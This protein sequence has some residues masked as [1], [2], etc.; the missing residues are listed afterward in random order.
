MK[1]DYLIVGAGLYGAVFAHEATERGKKCLVIEKRSHVGGNVFT[2]DIE[3]IQVHKYGAHIFHTNNK[4]IW[5]FVNKFGEFNGFINSPI[6]KYKNRMYSLPFNMNTFYQMWGIIDPEEAWNKIKLQKLQ[7]NIKIPKNLEEQAISLVGYDIYK[8]LIKGYTE[9]QW[10]R[11][12]RDLPIDIIKRL[13]VRYT[14][15]NNYFSDRYQGIPINGYTS[16]VKNMLKGVDVILNVNFLENRN[17][18]INLAKKVIYTGTIDGYF[19]YI[20]GP[21]N[22]RSLRFEVDILPVDNY[23]G[24]A[25]V[26]FPEKEIPYTRIIEHKHFVFGKQKNTVISREYPLEW[27]LGLEP[28]YPVNDIE[29]NKL[30]DKYTELARSLKNVHFAGRLGQYKYFNMD[31]VID[32]ALKFASNEFHAK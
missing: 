16:L 9:K 29:N 25:V 7:A 1:Y 24:V 15:D 23:Q 21:L 27:K 3:G 28:Y 2:E 17:E 26:N 20:Y 31:K 5:E 32:E 22:Y 13:P 19:D 10:G 11:D 12:C 4:E 6:A 18:L 14:F 30:F 8:I